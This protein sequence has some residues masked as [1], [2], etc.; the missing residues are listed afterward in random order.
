MHTCTNI[1]CNPAHDALVGKDSWLYQYIESK[2]LACIVGYSWISERFAKYTSKITGRSLMENLH[3]NAPTSSICKSARVTQ[4]VFKHIENYIMISVTF[5]P[6]NMYFVVDSFKR[7]WSLWVFQKLLFLFL[8]LFLLFLSFFSISIHQ[9]AKH[10][11]CFSKKK[12]KKKNV[13]QQ[14]LLYTYY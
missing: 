2:S 11:E 7:F 4:V 13:I 3:M 10:V 14:L 9:L 12:K 1:C 6:V 5:Q 8:F